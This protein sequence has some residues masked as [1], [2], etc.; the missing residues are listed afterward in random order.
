MWSSGFRELNLW[1]GP[2]L[3]NQFVVS[4]FPGGPSQMQS[5][6]PKHPKNILTTSSSST[7]QLPFR[8]PQLPSYGDPK[9][10]N[11]GPLV[12]VGST[13]RLKCSSLLGSIL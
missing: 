9:A 2:V 4:T 11:E 10:F 7:P 1:T 3:K 8:K 6:C 12:G 13:H 5:T